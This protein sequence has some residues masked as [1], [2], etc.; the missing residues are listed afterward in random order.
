MT[1]TETTNIPQIVWY[2]TK[3]FINFKIMINNAQNVEIDLT[4]NKFNFSSNSNEKLYQFHLDLLKEPEIMNYTI[5][6]INIDVKL[7]KKESEWW[8]S[9]FTNLEMK[10]RVKIDWSNW[11][12][13]DEDIEVNNGAMPSN[14]DMSSMAGMP[15]M[16]SM[17]GMSGMEGLDM[18]SL[19]NISDSIPGMK[20]MMANMNLS[21][22]PD[23]SNEVPENVEEDQDNEEQEDDEIDLE[24]EQDLSQVDLNDIKQEISNLKHQ[25]TSKLDEVIEDSNNIQIEEATEINV[26]NIS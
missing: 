19:G 3:Q 24:Q 5:N 6:G 10:N 25:D 4:E 15:G 1:I 2:Q 21:D 23:T 18:S 7:I 12:D 16:E 11:V 8:N 26:D 22:E 20:E 9:M 13:E 17:T 14:F